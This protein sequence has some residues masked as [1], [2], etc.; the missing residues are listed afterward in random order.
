METAGRMNAALG[1][2][3][4]APRPGRTK[5]RLAAHLGPAQAAQLSACFLRDVADAVLA[6]PETLGR[7]GYGVYAPA[8]SEAELAAI[9]PPA[10]RLVLQEGADFGVVLS[11]TVQRLLE[12]SH[13]C[14]VLIN[15]DSPTLPAALLTAAVTALRRPGDRVV[16]GPAIDGGYTLIGLKRHHPALFTDIPW[17]TGDVLRLTRARAVDG[18]LEVAMLPLWYDIDDAETLGLLQ[19]EIAGTPPAFA[20]PG[21]V[22]GP[23]AATRALLTQWSEA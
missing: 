9:L 6:V 21:I 2:M 16:L 1:I 11:T 15:S 4:K 20:T 12:H 14:V 19:A 18:G 22:G 8:G 17:S 13:D 5:T 3:C 7:Q 23:A 10:F